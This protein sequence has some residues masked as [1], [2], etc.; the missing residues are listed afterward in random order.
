MKKL[1]F[2]AASV[3]LL[4]VGI[5]AGTVLSTEKRVAHYGPNFVCLLNAE[6]AIECLGSDILAWFRV[7]PM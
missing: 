2:V 7:F 6:G 3:A 5:G 4:I 1:I